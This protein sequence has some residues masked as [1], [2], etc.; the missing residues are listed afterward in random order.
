MQTSEDIDDLACTLISAR[1][2]GWS[3]RAASANTRNAHIDDP[4]AA[5]DIEGMME[6]CHARTAQASILDLTMGT[7]QG[8]HI[9][10]PRGPN[11]AKFFR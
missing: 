3:D 9:F 10:T 11:E 4:K 6:L 1:K 2:R 8:T 5:K 7:R